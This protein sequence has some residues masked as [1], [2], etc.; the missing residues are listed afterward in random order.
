MISSDETAIRETVS[1]WMA[2]SQSGDVDT[3]LGLVADD[4]V[5]LA[6]G[7]PPMHKAEF[8]TLSRAQAQ[9]G[10]PEIAGDSDIQE[11]QVVGDWAFMWTRLRI[12]VTPPG[13]AALERAGH[14][15]TVLKKVAGRWVIARDANL[16]APVKP[17]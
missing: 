2:A 13:G 10:G 7:R 15:L 8:E 14:T 11:I 5:F 6:P 4:V 1:T 3:V 9:P 16:L 12:I 17:G